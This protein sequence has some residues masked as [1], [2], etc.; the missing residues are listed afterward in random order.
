MLTLPLVV[1]MS[2]ASSARSCPAAIEDTQSAK[3]PKGADSV[4]FFRGP[5]RFDGMVVFVGHPTKR[6][7][8]QPVGSSKTGIYT[9]DFTPSQD[10][11]IE[12]T[13]LDSAAI[14]TY[15]VGP[16]RKCSFTKSHG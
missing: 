15:H 13:Y 9:Y 7:E 4:Q 8:V 14:V 6:L 2:L 5:R 16:T 3:L 1:A 12:C 10:V 11:W